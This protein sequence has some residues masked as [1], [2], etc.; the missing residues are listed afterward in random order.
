MDEN[1]AEDFSF[2]ARTTSQQFQQ[3][4]LAAQQSSTER[5]IKESIVSGPCDC[6]QEEEQ[7]ILI[8]KI[9]I[10]QC[11]PPREQSGPSRRAT[12]TTL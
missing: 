6:Q 8:H 5:Q 4:L 11:R 7:R 9:G 12:S 2:D 3:R 10:T 1:N